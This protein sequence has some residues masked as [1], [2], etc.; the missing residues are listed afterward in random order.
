MGLYPPLESADGHRLQHIAEV[1]F[2]LEKERKFRAS[3]Y[4]KYKHGVNIVDRIV[5]ALAPTGVGLAASGIGLLSII[6]AAPVAI[7]IQAEAV[8]FGLGA[9]GKLIGRKFQ[10]KAKKHN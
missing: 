6:I 1:K 5:T 9:G 8:V 4:K 3:L 7:G 2:H 10:A